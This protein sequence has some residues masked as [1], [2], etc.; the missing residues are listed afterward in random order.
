MKKF[1]DSYDAETPLN[2]SL[3]RMPKRSAGEKPQSPFSG[4]ISKSKRQPKRTN[5][6]PKSLKEFIRK[7]KSLNTRDL[8]QNFRI[9]VSLPGFRA[10][11]VKKIRRWTRYFSIPG[12]LTV[13]RLK[14]TAKNA[15]NTDQQFGIIN[16]EIITE[17]ENN[18]SSDIKIK[19]HKDELLGAIK[20]ITYN[21]EEN[22][23]YIILNCSDFFGK[24]NRYFAIPASSALLK[25][26][27]KG[28]IVVKLD[29]NDLKLARGISAN[30]C[31][32]PSLKFEPSV[33]ELYNYSRSTD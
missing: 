29:K 30:R 16:E 11:I 28:E 31:P 20:K 1:T 5:S 12:L 13:D 14:E 15:Q 33:Y 24:K 27:E 26:T 18:R 2:R 17:L 21:E 22:I 23:Q 6:I 4:H 8:F 25:L 9:P 3:S 32:E 19:N 10:S 7:A